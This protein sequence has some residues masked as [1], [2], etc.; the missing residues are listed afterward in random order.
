MIRSWLQQI[1]LAEVLQRELV[2][3]STPPPPPFSHL[4][5]QEQVTRS[6]SAGVRSVRVVSSMAH[7]QFVS[8]L[9]FL[10]ETV[11]FFFDVV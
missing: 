9:E 10:L 4:L 5:V 11:S 2:N 8:V 3:V 7:A 1:L 6:C